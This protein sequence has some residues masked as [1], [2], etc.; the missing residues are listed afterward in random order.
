MTYLEQAT[1]H[2][3]PQEKRVILQMDEINIKYESSDKGGQSINPTLETDNPRPLFLMS[4]F[5]HILK[6]I[7]N[8]WINLENVDQTFIYPDLSTIH[9]SHITY[10]F[11]FILPHSMPLTSSISQINTKLAP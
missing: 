2:F 8:S 4:E 6:S 11:A 9:L 5:F 10:P 7:R 1:C 3:S